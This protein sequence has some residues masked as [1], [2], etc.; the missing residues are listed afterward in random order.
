LPA[1][2]AARLTGG[3]LVI[4]TVFS[5]G[6]PYG[7]TLLKKYGLLNKKKDIRSKK[8]KLGYG[9]RRLG[10]LLTLLHL[11]GKKVYLR[12]AFDRGLP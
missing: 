1:A 8:E 6:A 11:Q 2:L 4:L 7:S 3:A 9:N 10:R 5:A 12:D